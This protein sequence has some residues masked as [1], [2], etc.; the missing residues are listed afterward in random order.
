M[1]RFFLEK[2]RIE[3]GRA[4]L[5]GNEATHI[6][7]VLRLGVGDSLYLLD[8]EGWEYQAVITSKSSRVVE[9]ELLTKALRKKILQ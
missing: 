9:V 5:D 7:K 1:R 2:N 3:K 6:G 8:E 4:I